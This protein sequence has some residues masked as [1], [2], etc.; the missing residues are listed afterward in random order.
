MS[1]AAFVEKEM[2]DPVK[3]LLSKLFTSAVTKGVVDASSVLSTKSCSSGKD[4]AAS[5]LPTQK[6]D[7]AGSSGSVAIPKAATV[8]AQDPAVS[9]D[10]DPEENVEKSS[11]AEEVQTPPENNQVP[12]TEITNTDVNIEMLANE[13]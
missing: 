2:D 12:P 6:H 7:I 10:D 11:S 9:N 1:P 4:E 3:S 5:Q 13:S 8:E